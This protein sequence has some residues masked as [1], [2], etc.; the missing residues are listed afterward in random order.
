MFQRKIDDIFKDLPNGF[1]IAGDI[2]VVG[3]ET[4]DK[5]HNETVD[6]V[7]QRYR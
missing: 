2:L 4:D 6:R 5:D 1:G 3:Y 7:L